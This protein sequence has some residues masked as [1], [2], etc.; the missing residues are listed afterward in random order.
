M[1]DVRVVKVK[2][3]LKCSNCT[4]S[5]TIVFVGSNQCEGCDHYGGHASPYTKKEYR[6]IYCRY[7][8]SH[9]IKKCI[10]CGD[11]SDTMYEFCQDDFCED[12]V[13]TCNYCGEKEDDCGCNSDNTERFT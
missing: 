12:C 13:P 8:K 6:S 3:N 2:P 9:E 7:Q 4:C 1:S 10:S 11:T 5:E